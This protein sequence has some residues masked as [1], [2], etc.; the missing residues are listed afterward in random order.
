MNVNQSRVKL[1]RKCHYAHYLKYVELLKVKRKKRPLVFG[2]IVHEMV[3]ADANANDPMEVLEEIEKK[4][5]KVFAIERE[6][7]GDLVSDI[8]CIMSEYFEYYKD[9]TLQYIRKNKKSAEHIFEVEI[10]KGLNFKGKIDGIA[11]TGAK[12]KRTWLVEHKSSEKAPP[13]EDHRWRNVQSAVYI[14]AT[15]MMG[16]PKLDGTMWDYIL[17]KPPARPEVLKSG[18]LSEKKISSLPSRVR[19][20]LKELGLK[21][22]DHRKLIE[23]AEANRRNYFQRIFSPLKKP[24]VDIVFGDFVRSAKEIRDFGEKAKDRSIDKH[25]DWCEFEPLC[26]ATMQGLDV[27]FIKEREYEAHNPEAHYE[28]E[29][30]VTQD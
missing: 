3:D 25:C 19:E 23:D 18:K 1:W 8:R 6:M 17:S 12:D 2:T 21:E 5:K 13:N 7:Y 26:R 9:S 16:W 24:V 4:E 15:E 30:S 20:T 22:K 27:D 28:T 11:K 10:D 14:R 29:R